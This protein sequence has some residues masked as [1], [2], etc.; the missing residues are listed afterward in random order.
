MAAAK[1][2]AFEFRGRLVTVDSK[3]P[4]E[5]SDWQGTRLEGGALVITVEVPR[6]K[7]PEAPKKNYPLTLKRPADP[8]PEP[9]FTTPAQDAGESAADFKKRTKEASAAHAEQLQ[10]WQRARGKVD[11]WEAA[12]VKHNSLVEKH[13]Q[14]SE[15][16]AGEFAAYAQMAGVGA[17]IQGLPVR[18]ALTPDASAM[19]TYLPGFSPAGLLSAPAAA[20][21]E[22]EP[23][24]DED[25]DEPDDDDAD[26]SW[27]EDE[28][29]D[30]E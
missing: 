15:R 28:E 2:Q 24:Q 11:E 21:F 14:A 19:R 22:D 12:L 17:L 23:E 4:K 1:K 5:K 27:D 18:L 3:A 10:A 20:A 29:G 6:P 8:G 9:V 13:R 16:V 26:G 25:G 30:E 7:L